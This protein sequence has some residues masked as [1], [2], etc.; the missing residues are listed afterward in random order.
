V[1]ILDGQ[2]RN[3][4]VVSVIKPVPPSNVVEI[5]LEEVAQP[6]QVV[7]LPP[8]VR[9][10]QSS[11]ISGAVPRL[12]DPPGCNST[13]AL[14]RS[15]WHRSFQQRISDVLQTLIEVPPPHQPLHHLEAQCLQMIG[16]AE[17]LLKA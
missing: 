14:L 16:L 7:V 12:R 4:I 17:A 1:G 15:T 2:Q 3:V 13:S 6:P 11:L 5:R 8:A 9:G 10:Q